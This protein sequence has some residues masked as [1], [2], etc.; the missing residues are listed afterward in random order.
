[1]KIYITEW[2]SVLFLLLVLTGCA[3]KNDI[4]NSNIINH[5]TATKNQTPSIEMEMLTPDYSPIP[6][7]RI[8]SATPSKTACPTSTSTLTLTP[9]DKPAI[10][11]LNQD[12]VCYQGPGYIYDVKTYL[13]AGESVMAVGKVEDESWTL[14]DLSDR[15]ENCWLTTERLTSNL[16]EYDLNIV[17]PPP[18]PTEKVSV[19]PEL[20][21][22]RTYLFVLNTG[23]PFGCGDSLVYYYSGI[24]TTGDL[25]K[26]VAAIL[27]FL[28]KQKQEYIG[29]NYNPLYKSNLNIKNVM[30]DYSS[31]RANIRLGGT[32]I[33]PSNACES[34]RIRTQ[35]WNT[36]LQ[37]DEIDS[38][39]IWVNNKL[40]GDLLYVGNK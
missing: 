11:S 28:L 10:F 29:N 36:I 20:H 21:G 8:A 32:F 33:K 2:I 16:D 27:R 35:I 22:M 5:S 38:A 37:F 18:T 19:T 26:D 17:S 23:G 30:I 7:T 4:D 6:T 1:M 24:K 25:E 3:V 14:V 40:L 39:Q 12:S 13:S 34:E 9:T 15:D 31:K